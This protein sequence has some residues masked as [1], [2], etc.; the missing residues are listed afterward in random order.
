M[1]LSGTL[2]AMHSVDLAHPN[3]VQTYKS[4]QKNVS[5]RRVTA[6]PPRLSPCTLP[7]GA[8]VQQPR[9]EWADSALGIHASRWGVKSPAHLHQRPQLGCMQLPWHAGA[10]SCTWL[11]T[12]KSGMSCRP[13]PQA[14]ACLVAAPLRAR[15]GRAADGDRDVAGARVL[16][17]GQPAGPG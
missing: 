16:R 6:C 11:C 17:P 1:S 15:A 13:A 10:G 12:S 7:G 9:P 2:E 5:V 8:P 14:A 4:T 3:V